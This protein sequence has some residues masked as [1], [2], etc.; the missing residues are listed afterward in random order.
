MVRPSIQPSSF[1]RCTRASTQLL[2][3]AAEPMLKNPMVGS[4]PVCCACVVWR[5]YP[6]LQAGEG[7]FFSRDIKTMDGL[8]I[9]TLA[10]RAA[11][12]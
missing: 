3:A 6:V 1:S 12:L 11:L 10:L 2:T 8:F 7:I 9:H 5:D 4:L